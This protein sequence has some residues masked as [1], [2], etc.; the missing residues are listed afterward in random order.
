M[1]SILNPETGGTRGRRKDAPW[2]SQTADFPTALGNPAKCAGFPLSHRSGGGG[3]LTKP[4]IS[5]ATK[6]GHFNLLRTFQL[7]L[8]HC[9]GILASTLPDQAARG[10]QNNLKKEVPFEP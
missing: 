9:S 6:S 1:N 7:Q 5:L 2:K 3:R 10:T 4:D 8:S